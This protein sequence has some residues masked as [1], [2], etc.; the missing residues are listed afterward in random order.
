MCWRIVLSA[1]AAIYFGGGGNG[2]IGVGAG[3]AAVGAGVPEPSGA[4]LPGAAAL[5]G[6]AASAAGAGGAFLWHPAATIK[7]V[8]KTANG[9]FIINGSSRHAEC[10]FSG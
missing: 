5:S 1:L 4:G 6:V 9:G 7:H 3:A 10:G 2:V 8:A